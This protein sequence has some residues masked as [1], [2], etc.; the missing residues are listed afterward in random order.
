MSGANNIFYIRIVITK[1]KTVVHVTQE[2]I[3]NGVSYEP[4]GCPVALALKPHFDKKKVNI[5]VAVEWFEI[6]SVSSHS[7]DRRITLPLIARQFIYEFDA[8]KPV[9]PFSFEVDL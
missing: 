7:I 4:C 1:M 9:E 3:D 6:S 8:R 5:F 2:C